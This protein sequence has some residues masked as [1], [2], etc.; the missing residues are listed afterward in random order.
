[1]KNI[2]NNLYSD[3]A[4]ATVLGSVIVDPTLLLDI[5]L[6]PT[7]F[8]FKAN[9]NIYEA[10]L[11]LGID[12]LNFTS[13]VDSLE[14][15]NKLNQ[16]GGVTYISKLI[17]FSDGTKNG[18]DINA[19]L[20][21]EYSLKRNVYN[22]LETSKSNLGSMQKEE[23]LKISDDIKDIYK[24]TE[25]NIESLFI[26]ASTIDRKRKKDNYIQT[27]FPKL[28]AILGGG[29]IDGT[30]T[31]LTGTPSSGKSTLTN[32]IAANAIDQGFKTFIYS[33]ELTNEMLMDWF[34]KTVS[35]ES[36]L[37]EKYNICNESY[38][39]PSDY[40][41]KLIQ[42]WVKE[43][44]FIYSKTAKATEDNLVSVIEFLAAK[45]GVKFFILDNLMTIESS[46]SSG[47]D[48]YQKQIAIVSAIKEI[49]KNLG[50]VVILVAHPNKESNKSNE[51]SMYDV[52]G[53]AEIVNLADY[54][55]KNIRNK[56]APS[57]LV[58]LKNRITGKNGKVEIF[59][60]DKR[61][62]FSTETGIELRKDFGYNEKTTAVQAS[63]TEEKNDE[64]I[65]F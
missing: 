60:N 30:M 43:K 65:P 28:D 4:E 19:N 37:E 9:Q 1:M 33:G 36:D 32:Q 38:Y 13:L 27:G 53:A 31:I 39:I 45:K 21:K 14:K 16:S 29:L 6:K 61:K 50:L 59:F 58:V 49:A 34:S 57:L 11:I 42:D 3:I 56:E 47:S 26:D 51:H 22:L 24:D 5:N 17:T 2:K 41:F 23:V 18:I 7:D 52:S 48:K 12:Q 15:N 25:S 55:I 63:F 20:V 46:A 62:R 40:S 10:I 54:C 64:E 8:Y 44:F 35:N